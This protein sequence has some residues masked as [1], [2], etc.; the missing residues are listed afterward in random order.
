MFH[1][2]TSWPYDNQWFQTIEEAI[3]AY[4]NQVQPSTEYYIEIQI[5][6]YYWRFDPSQATYRPPE[7][8]PL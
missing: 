8:C 6:S 7:Q 1:L 3:D 4:H 2:V 5:G